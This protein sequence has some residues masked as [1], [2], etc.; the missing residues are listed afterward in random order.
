MFLLCKYGLSNVHVRVRVCRSRLPGRARE[1]E[2]AQVA[3]DRYLRGR[4]RGAA[5]GRTIKIAV[6]LCLDDDDDDFAD[7][8]AA[9]AP[10]PNF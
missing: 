4:A 9:S 10:R 6:I 8:D 2:D 5:G 1:R 7:A 3:H